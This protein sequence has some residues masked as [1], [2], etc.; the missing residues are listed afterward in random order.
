LKGEME[1]LEK[2]GK[3]LSERTYLTSILFV[4]LASYYASIALTREGSENTRISEHALMPG[5]VLPS[6]NKD[7][8][9]IK[10]L[11]EL[12]N[13]KDIQSRSEYIANEM[14]I[15]SIDSYV[16]KWS[17]STIFKNSSGLSTVSLLRAYRSTGAETMI[18]VTRMEDSHAVAMTMAL[19]YHSRDHSHWSRDIFF[20][21]VDGGEEGLDAWLEEYYGLDTRNKKEEEMKGR[22]RFVVGALVL[23]TPEYLARKYVV[24]VKVNGM[25][26]QLPNLDLFN[27]V[28]R[29]AH[30]GRNQLNVMVYSGEEMSP[31]YDTP[32]VPLRFL[33]NQAFS[34]VEGMHSLFSKYGVQAITIGGPR[35]KAGEKIG[36]MEFLMEGIIRSLNNLHERFHQSYFLYILISPGFFSSIA[37]YL[38]IV[39]LLIAPLIILLNHQALHEWL[40]I[41]SS[42]FRPDCSFVFLFLFGI[43]SLLVIDPLVTFTSI[44]QE[45][46]TR[47]LIAF[48][49]FPLGLF[50]KVDSLP[51]SRF[52]L[53]ISTSLL[54]G[55]LSLLN[56]A[57][58][59]FSSIAVL[60]A[61][62][63]TL[64]PA[65]T[66]LGRIT[67]VLLL[68]FFNPIALIILGKLAIVSLQYDWWS[69]LDHKLIEWGLLVGGPQHVLATVYQIIDQFYTLGSW[70]LP[71][72]L[73]F[74]GPLW[75]S[76]LALASTADVQK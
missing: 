11:R 15:F 27:S 66:R 19:A 56:F 29:I 5:I 63:I 50:V 36:R 25:N 47:L 65:T 23:E 21:F 76:L 17:K 4:S 54:L 46:I 55:S 8:Q 60:P 72:L 35:M 71:L 70:H 68:S 44:D 49:L 1:R 58:A 22:G 26:G 20:V 53:L 38:P 42:S 9:Q 43:G 62:L 37:F 67:R 64:A 24:D 52:L 16:H 7:S 13:M 18:V 73:I 34:G 75:N 51:S 40:S 57:L 39:G 30:R 45:G 69:H 2:L 61:V 48:L 14:N 74:A 32:L 6:F 31:D 3:K 33:L 12:M 59:L 10:W 41:P 28:A